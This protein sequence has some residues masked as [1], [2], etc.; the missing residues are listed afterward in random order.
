MKEKQYN[1]EKLTITITVSRQVNTDEEFIDFSEVESEKVYPLPDT[2]K[3]EI[4]KKWYKTYLSP[5]VLY[6]AFLGA[7]ISIGLAYFFS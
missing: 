3:K 7:C 1:T 6:Q 2:E 4:P 5:F